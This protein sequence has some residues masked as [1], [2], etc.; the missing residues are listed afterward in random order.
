M[1]PYNTPIYNYLREYAKKNI[2][3]FHMPGHKLSRGIPQELAQEVLKLDVTEIEGTDNLHYPEGIIKEAEELAAKAFGADKTFFL[4]NGSTCGIQAAI[5]SVCAR[6]QK[7]IIGRDSHKSVVSGL[8]LS[9]AEPVF[10]Y[11]QYICDFGITGAITAKSIEKLLCQ[12][13][14]AVAVLI[15]RPNYY[16]IC[17]SI[18]EISSLV[19]SHNKLLIVDEAH[20]A[21]LAFNEKLPPSAI[22]H[23]ADICIQSAHK[24]L[25]A[26]TQGAY[27]HVNGNRVDTDRLKLNLS[28]LQTSSPSYILMSYLDIARELMER[29]GAQKLD[30][31]IDEIEWFKKELEKCPEYRVLSNS[32]YD[33]TRLVINI[34]K[35]GISGYYAEKLLREKFKTQ[36]EMA[37]FENLVF[38][39]TTADNH[40]TFSALL[41]AM[42]GLPKIIDYKKK[43]ENIN[44][45]SNIIKKYYK[46]LHNNIINNLIETNGVTNMR[47]AAVNNI[48]K[49]VLPYEAYTAIKE[50]I[51]IYESCGRICADVITPYPPGIPV[52]YPGEIIEE[53]H[54]QYI[55][56]IAEIGGTINGLSHNKCVQV[57]K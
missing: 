40:E 39:T 4:V 19:H 41:D 12:H 18:E 30:L 10:A 36:V 32:M 8:I 42:K 24:T 28:M 57:V 1:N 51:P 52:L 50:K 53:K 3:I 54:I 31:L 25:P 33:F 26:L 38:I 5:M 14:D 48:N 47:K 20:G 56:A 45:N 55:T 29:E 17:S 9:G 13:P 11:P 34:S 16:G 22:K 44:M 15:T 37:D 23:G 21:H 46:E 43:T 7:I 49:G 35:L 6:G 2:N 27:L